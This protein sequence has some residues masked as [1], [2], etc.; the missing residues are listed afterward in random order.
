MLSHFSCVWLFATLWTIGCQAPL[1]MG[2][3][4]QKY[5]SGSPC[6]SPGNLP[7]PRIEPSSPALQADSL[8]TE[9][10]GNPIVTLSSFKFHHKSDPADSKSVGSWYMVLYYFRVKWVLMISE[11][12]PACNQLSPVCLGCSWCCHSKTW[13]LG[14]HSV[15]GKWEF[16]A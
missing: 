15:L 9:P 8:P 16:L 5:W 2:F 11:K 14:N 13:V 7:N 4:W 3:S 1:S 6:P 10:P 12:F